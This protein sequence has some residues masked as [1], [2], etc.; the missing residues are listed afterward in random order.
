MA[1]I[2]ASKA[3]ANLYRLID[4]VIQSHEPMEILGKRGN[5][6]LISLDDW[7]WISDTIHLSSIPGMVESV[8]K[9]LKTPV[10][11]C[12]KKLKW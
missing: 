12:V 9:G 1:A 10:S 8:K 2:T 6:V 4:Q 11:K 5:A 7:R 3:R